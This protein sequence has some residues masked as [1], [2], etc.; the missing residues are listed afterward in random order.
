MAHHNSRDASSSPTQNSPRFQPIGHRIDGYEPYRGNYNNGGAPDT[1]FV[2]DMN[3]YGGFSNPVP[4]DLPVLPLDQPLEETPAASHNDWIFHQQVPSMVRPI[5]Y[6]TDTTPYAL[7]QILA[8]DFGDMRLEQ[9]P[10]LLQA[11]GLN[12]P[13]PFNHFLATIAHA[14]PISSPALAD[15]STQPI[16]SAAFTQFTG[17]NTPGGIEGEERIYQCTE[18][19]NK[20]KFGS[21]GDLKKHKETARAHRVST[22]RLYRCSCGYEQARK[23]NYNRHLRKC[24]A[25]CVR[26]QR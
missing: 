3:F 20:P 7:D 10:L 14:P 4:D 18:C 6:Y 17:D 21:K 8:L 19:P 24:N 2:N 26:N 5:A 22:T 12:Y 13:D 11:E 25:K 16:L 1:S 23:D 15:N 9:D